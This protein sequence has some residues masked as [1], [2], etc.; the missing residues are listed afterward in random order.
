MFARYRTPILLAV[1]LLISPR[2]A[3]ADPAEVNVENFARA[4]SVLYLAR[5]VAQGAFGRLV[6]AGV[7]VAIDQQHVIRMNRDTIYSIG[8]FGLT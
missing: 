7:P 3:S 8:V 1:A 5:Y 4:E 2:G 6:H